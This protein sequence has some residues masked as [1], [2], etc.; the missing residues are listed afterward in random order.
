[1]NFYKLLGLSI[2]P[3]EE[4]EEIIKDKIL[5]KRKEW[6]RDIKN[7]KKEIEAKKYISLV[8]QIEKAMLNPNERKKQ[9]EIALAEKEETKKV[10]KNELNIITVKGYIE[11]ED[12]ESLYIKY[13]G[14]FTK[15]EIIAMS[16]KPVKKEELIDFTDKVTIK[17]LEEAFKN[18]KI[19]N[20]SL[21]NFLGVKMSSSLQICIDACNKK[22]NYI[23][24][25]GK[26]EYDDKIDIE[27][28]TIAKE[29]IFNSVENRT[30]YNNYIIGNTYNKL[31]QL[32]ISG[33]K[34]NKLL[35]QELFN[36]LYMVAKNDYN[37]TESEFKEYINYN[38]KYY[39][40]EVRLKEENDGKNINISKLN[41]NIKEEKLSDVKPFEKK[42][43]ASEKMESINQIVNPFAEYLLGKVNEIKDINNSVVEMQRTRL[44]QGFHPDEMQT[45]VVIVLGI[46]LL[47][48]DVVIYI[49]NPML[50]PITLFIPIFVNLYFSMRCF[51]YS[52]QWNDLKEISRKIN[53]CSVEAENLFERKLMKKVMK[54]TYKLDVSKTTNDINSINNELNLIINRMSLL[55]E[56]YNSKNKR[57]RIPP[58][59]FDFS[60]DVLYVF[61]INIAYM[62]ILI[63][64]KYIFGIGENIMF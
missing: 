50:K 52:R 54:E 24:E 35:S 23:L 64:Y 20:L 12:I 27:I 37:M 3:P 42:P 14:D 38:S 43:T 25:K 8:P 33:V 40:Y 21:Y 15:K 53:D 11:K 31:N 58:K 28:L 61:G 60:K 47:I 45:S 5:E 19:D 51:S 1:M 56:K 57:L 36:A 26:K 32:V 9:I 4:N 13:N 48:A 59:G 18:K 62:G 63:G 39:M 49:I 10:L 6:Q 7:P 46:I 55:I 34:S 22:K 29:K 17:K 41:K 2:N 44:Q 30:K 16:P